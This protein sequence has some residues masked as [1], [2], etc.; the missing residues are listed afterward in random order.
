[1]PQNNVL[2][3]NIFKKALLSQKKVVNLRIFR[4]CMQAAKCSGQR[5]SKV[6]I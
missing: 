2:C 6:E 4:S 1:M 3:I 5:Q